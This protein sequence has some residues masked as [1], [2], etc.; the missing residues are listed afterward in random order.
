MHPVINR[1]ASKGAITK[2]EDDNGNIQSRLRGDV[3]AI[4]ITRLSF[5]FYA[6]VM[7]LARQLTVCA[8]L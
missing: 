3:G 4:A 5:L 6:R 1:L 2:L 8:I 7:D